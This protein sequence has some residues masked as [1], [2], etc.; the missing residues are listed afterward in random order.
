MKE[1]AVRSL[2]LAGLTLAAAAPAP[3]QQDTTRLPPGVELA[4]RYTR[5]GR[6]LVAVRPFAGPVAMDLALQVAGVI[7]NDLLISDR[8]EMASPP[9]SLEAG[10]IDYAIWNSLK[11]VYLVSG[12]LAETP[13]GGHRLDITLH[14]VVYGNVLQQR[15]FTL[16]PASAPDFRMSIHA[17]SDEIVRWITKQPGMAASRVAFV[18]QNGNRSYDLML[19]DADG[20]NLRRLVGSSNPIYSPAWSP[21]GRRLVY[22]I[23]TDEGY[24]FVERDMESGR[25]RTVFASP[26]LITTPAYS[27]DGTRLVFG[28]WLAAGHQLHEYDVVRGCCLKRLTNTRGGDNLSP[29]FSP[30]GSRLAFHSNRTGR[31]HI[32]VMDAAGASQTIL[33]PF[34]ERVEYYAPD[35]SPTGSE[36]VFHGASRG[37]FQLM[38]ADASRPGSQIQQLTSTGR[39]EDPS[40]A[41]DGRHVVFTGVAAGAVGLYVIDTKTGQVRRVASGPLR[42]AEW[43]PS[44]A[45]AAGVAQ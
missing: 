29:T 45:A 41:P 27:P 22:R 38:L 36:V 14:D 8:F 30:D 16:P 10:P 15:G 26:N 7:R 19:V 40:W 1:H 17:A 32:F 34:G 33:S 13:G 42:A 20:E 12:A 23:E 35:W 18:R 24:A 25:T 28:L 39:N 2:L 31:Q 5:L 4:T 43:S 3:A 9:A 21:D 11:V 44:L 6:P 37:T